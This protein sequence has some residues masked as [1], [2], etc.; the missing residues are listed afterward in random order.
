MNEYLLIKMMSYRN[1]N[2]HSFLC[3][4]IDFRF[5]LCPP[6]AYL[7]SPQD[8]TLKSS[9]VKINNS[10]EKYDAWGPTMLKVRS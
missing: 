4:K 5:V 2:K 3:I 6:C 1:K 10:L 7:R 9:R 8:T